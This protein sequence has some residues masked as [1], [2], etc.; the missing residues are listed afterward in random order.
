MLMSDHAKELRNKRVALFIFV[1]LYKEVRVSGK[2]KPK[3][4]C[5]AVSQ[6]QEPGSVFRHARHTG[7]SP[8]EFRNSFWNQFITVVLNYFGW[9][10]R[11]PDSIH[12]HTICGN[13]FWGFKHHTL[14]LS[15]FRYKRKHAVFS[16]FHKY[17]L[18]G[19]LIVVPSPLT[20][21]GTLCFCQSTHH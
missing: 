21:E 12:L 18:S 10:S 15:A 17:V 7:L 6:G 4:W 16:Q 9:T 19:V 5:V 8:T 13:W 3:G 14:S 11:T 2:Q 20:P 1:S